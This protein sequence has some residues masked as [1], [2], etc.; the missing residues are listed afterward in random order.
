MLGQLACDDKSNEITTIPKLLKM[1][2]LAG[3][4]VT[5][6]A[7]GCQREI[8]RQIIDQKGHGAAG[9]LH[10]Q[11]DAGCGLAGARAFMAW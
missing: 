2:H 3:L 7:M 6:D 5:I 11:R 1:L 10:R 9:L 4:T 8:A